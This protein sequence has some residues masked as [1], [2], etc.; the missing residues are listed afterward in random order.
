MS[1]VVLDDSFGLVVPN[2]NFGLCYSTQEAVSQFYLHHWCI[3]APE[4][5]NW[6]PGVLDSLRQ[7][8]IEY[9]PTAGNLRSTDGSKKRYSMNNWRNVY[10]EPWQDVLKHCFGS[11]ECHFDTVCSGILGLFD[12]HRRWFF[13]IAGG[14]VVHPGGEGQKGHSDDS[15]NYGRMPAGLACSIYVTDEINNVGHAP[16]KI[17]SGDMELLV[18]APLGSILIRDVNV[19]HAG[20][21]NSDADVRVLPSIRLIHKGHLGTDYR[22]K[23]HLSDDNFRCFFP[24]DHMMERMKYLWSKTYHGDTW[25]QTSYGDAVSQTSSSMEVSGSDDTG[26]D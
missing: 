21:S 20:T 13:D 10:A 17:W 15:T 3:L 4:A 24:G 14:D 23:R 1:T 16:M 2:D 11:A 9:E 6:P 22:P 19:W 25:S 8:C 18:C 26:S 7:W 5:M 12:R